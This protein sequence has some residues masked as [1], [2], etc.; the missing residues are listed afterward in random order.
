MYELAFIQGIRYRVTIT[1]SSHGL[2]LS[3]TASNIG[4]H[5]FHDVTVFPRLGHPSKGFQYPELRRTFIIT[6]RGMQAVGEIERGAIDP[7]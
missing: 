6:A 4:D 2:D 3:F 7:Q 5:T 1:P